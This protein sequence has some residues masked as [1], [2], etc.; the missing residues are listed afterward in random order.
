[1]APVD[2]NPEE[3]AAMGAAIQVREEPARRT[4]ERGKGGGGSSLYT[5]P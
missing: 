3:G 4:L 1:M 2:I 5:H